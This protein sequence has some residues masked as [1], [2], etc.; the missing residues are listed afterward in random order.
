MDIKDKKRIMK[1]TFKQSDKFLE[2]CYSNFSKEYIIYLY[3][4]YRCMASVCGDFKDI[5]RI[6]EELTCI[7]FKDNC[8]G[9]WFY[10]RFDEVSL[11][12]EYGLDVQS[13]E[14]LNGKNR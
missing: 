3:H 1:K 2:V 5:S 10:A 4:D 14:V 13:F 9:R 8:L 12:G 11:F 7:S 6:F